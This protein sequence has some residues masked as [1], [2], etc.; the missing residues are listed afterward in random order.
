MRHLTFARLA[1]CLSLAATVSVTLSELHAG[2][3][4]ASE[5]VATICVDSL[6]TFEQKIRDEYRQASAV[7]SGEVRSRTLEAVTVSVIQAW[8]GKLDVEVA[9]STGVRDNKDG[10]HTL[11]SESFHFI[12]GQKYVLFAYGK[13]DD[14]KPVG[15]LSTS[16]CQ[17]NVRLADA[18]PTI[19]VLDQIV[20]ESK[21]P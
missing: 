8:K 11:T 7:F 19:V 9:M 6:K 15:M 2:P 13:S 20:K 10:T 4:T 16:I 12:H 1:G 3:H 18:G 21:S 17:P 14:G 5:R